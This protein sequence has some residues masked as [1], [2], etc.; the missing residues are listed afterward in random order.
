MDRAGPGACTAM[1]WLAALG[2]APLA[3]RAGATCVVCIEF[4][5][6]MALGG[7]GGPAE[8]KPVAV[9]ICTR[10]AGLIGPLPVAPMPLPARLESSVWSPGRLLSWRD[11]V[12]PPSRSANG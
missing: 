2:D 4:A 9:L 1:S 3:G 5:A 6:I 10:I 12:L 7:A 8:A 11:L